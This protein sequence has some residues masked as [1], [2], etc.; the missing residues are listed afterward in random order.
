MTG[1]SRSPSYQLFMLALCLFALGTLA[2]HSFVPL[3]DVS[4]EI[5]EYTDA[6]ICGLFLIDFGNSLARAPN[7]W[8]YLYTWG[9]LDLLSSIP[10]IPALRLGR[11][12]RVVR[13]VRVMRGVRATKILSGLVLD[14]RAE[15]A[16]LAAALVTLL[17]VVFS[18]LAIV[19]F[20]TGPDA[21]IKTA[22]DALWWA[23]STITTVGYGDRFP[24]TPEGRMVAAVLM[25]AGIALFGVVS[26]FVAAWFLAPANKAQKSELDEVRDELRTLRGVLEERL[27]STVT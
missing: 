4:R 1:E 3:S 15:S 18:S 10:A 5:L 22:S 17:L 19:Q 12:G 11:A 16:G 6:A 8:R 27:R 26:G 14:R 7:R 23:L 2:V 25:M 21:N 9:W 20:E 13:I 24:V